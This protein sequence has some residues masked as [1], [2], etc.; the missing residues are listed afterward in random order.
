MAIE[1]LPGKCNE[2][3]RG[4]QGFRDS[5]I[6]QFSDVIRSWVVFYSVFCDVSFIVFILSMTFFWIKIELPTTSVS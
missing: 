6:K 5:L 3:L 4:K 1:Q 2:V